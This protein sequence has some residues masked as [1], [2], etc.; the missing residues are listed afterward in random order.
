MKIN[1]IR[2]FLP[3][4]DE[5]KENFSKCLE[6]GMVTNNC[7][8]VVEL[9]ERLGI[10]FSSKNT[11]LLFCN[12]E[13]ALYNLIQAWKIKLGYSHHETFKVLVPS[14]TFSGTI[15]A[16]VANN[17]TPVFC[18]V[19]DTLTLD[20]KKLSITSD[21]IK[22][23][24][25]VSA[26]GNLPNI[27]EIKK[28]CNDNNLVLIIDNAPAFGATQNGQ[29]ACNHGIDVIYS[30]HASKIYNSMEGG[31]AIT[32]D[33]EIQN[34]LI[35]LR[36]FGQFEKTRGNVNWPGLNSKMQEISAIIGLRNLEKINYILKKRRHNI[37]KYKTF[38][39]EL[40]IMGFLKTMLVPEEN[41][42]PYLYFPVILNEEA[43]EFV[44]HMQENEVM[45]RR[46]YTAV[47]RLKFY[48]SRYECL[49]LEQ[50]ESIKDRI[51]SL[52]LFTVMG[53]DEM[54]YLFETVKKYFIKK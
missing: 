23:V 6:T 22:M 3:G 19:D 38:F 24:L 34:I 17:L 37:E 14:F 1:I 48:D 25:P 45:V 49:N 26:Y 51:V 36:D 33:E 16:I 32:S 12:G 54:E 8:N 5:I 20:P 28:F 18:D 41:F 21:E 46:Y 11:P 40:E 27:P 43:T 52:P 35:Q 10:F 31:L 4:L 2:P 30:L 47:H 50:T 9:Q 42:C 13:M 15:N 7:P 53:E 39:S 44:D 29:F